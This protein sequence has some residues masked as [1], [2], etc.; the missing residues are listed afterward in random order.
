MSKEEEKKKKKSNNND[1]VA[2]FRPERKPKCS[3]GSEVRKDD[4]VRHGR[5][6]EGSKWYPKDQKFIIY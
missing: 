4:R 1:S 6:K 3:V 2:E 5:G